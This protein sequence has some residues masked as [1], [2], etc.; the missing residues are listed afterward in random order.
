MNDHKPESWDE[1]AEATIPDPTAEPPVDWDV[2]EDGEW[3]AAMIPNP[4]CETGCG[5][6]QRKSIKNPEYKGKW[7]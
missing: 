4:K 3:T 6:W 7:R 1:S 2:E 5:Q